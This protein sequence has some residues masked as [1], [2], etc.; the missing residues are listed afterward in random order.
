M[1]QT[2]A[3]VPTSLSTYTWAL[4][5]RRASSTY[6]TVKRI[7]DVVVALA[8]LA[9]LGP[10][11]GVAALLIKLT[12]GGPVLFRQRRVGKGGEE[13][14]CYKLR[15]MVTNADALKAKLAAQSHH[16]DPRTFKMRRDPRVTWIGRILRK[17]SLDE[18]PQ[19]FNV[20]K[21]DMTL[22]GPR[23][24]LPGEVAQYTAEE[25]RRLAVTPGITC[26]WQVSGRG[27]L[28]FDRQVALDIEYIQR[29]DLWLDLKLMALTIPAVVSGR[30]AY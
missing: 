17:T 16:A 2:Y 19:L 14:D 27:D 11:L 28:P 15:S 26:L 18:M 12:D 22:V 29:R 23:P 10:V 3:S 21:G 30:G 7:L 4:P 9:I 1:S 6:E 5:R 20:L 24:A 25:R 13:F 8:A